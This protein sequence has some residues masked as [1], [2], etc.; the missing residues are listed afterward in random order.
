MHVHQTRACGRLLDFDDNKSGVRS[1][2]LAA[3]KKKTPVCSGL[4]AV[5]RYS[6]VPKCSSIDY[7]VDAKITI[8]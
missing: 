7:Q 5:Y 1:E 3:V 2:F 6:K 4:Y 8:C